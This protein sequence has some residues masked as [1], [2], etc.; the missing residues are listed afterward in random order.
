LK[1]ILAP[2]ALMVFMSAATATNVATKK[3]NPNLP[4]ATTKGAVPAKGPKNT[5]QNAL[6][7]VLAANS[8]PVPLPPSGGTGLPKCESGLISGE[9]NGVVVC[10]DPGIDG[11]GGSSDGGG[12]DGTDEFRDPKEV[13]EFIDKVKQDRCD[14]LKQDAMAAAQFRKDKRYDF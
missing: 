14:K 5:A 6:V 9:S 7:G 2:V 10:V 3:S 11:G 4:N 12:H 8:E 1:N 13:Q